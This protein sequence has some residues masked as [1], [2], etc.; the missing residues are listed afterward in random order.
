VSGRIAAFVAGVS[1]ALFAVG[2]AALGLAR[3]KPW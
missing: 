1:F 2:S 3:R